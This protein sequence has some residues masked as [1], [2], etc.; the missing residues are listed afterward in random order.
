MSAFAWW[1]VRLTGKAYGA[2]VVA[3]AITCGVLFALKMAGACGAY[4]PL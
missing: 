1:L 2:F 4:N 3:V